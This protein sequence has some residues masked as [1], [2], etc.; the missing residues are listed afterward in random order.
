MS[1]GRPDFHPTML[2]EGKFGDTLIP[3]LTDALGQLYTVMS[4]YF[5]GV[6]T[7][8]L[9]D[10]AGRILAH[11]VGNDGGTIRDITVDAD[12]KLIIQVQGND[13]GTLRTVAVDPSGY[14]LSR[15]KG[16]DGGTMRDIAV[17]ASGRMIALIKGDD[18]GTI[19]TVAVDVDGVMKAN[20]SAQELDYLRVR[21]N[22]GK[23][24]RV[25][26]TGQTFPSHAWYTCL[27]TAGR[28]FLLGGWIQF[29]SYAASESGF[30]RLVID[31]TNVQSLSL[32]YLFAINAVHPQK[33]MFWINRWTSD[34]NVLGLSISPGVTFESSLQVQAWNVSGLAGVISF[35]LYY[36]LVP[37]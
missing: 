33:T 4:G 22:Y 31:G 17:D 28:G 36:A 20:L 3:I 5:G 30:A 21:P 19:R 37:T 15:M 10:A 12:G 27:D 24:Q 35:E 18:A 34:I 25:S 1:S 2:L 8:I 9:L 32:G 29:E 16:S 23:T 26:A 14:I 13:A 6:P 11:L 7:P